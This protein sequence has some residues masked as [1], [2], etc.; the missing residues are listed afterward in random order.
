MPHPFQDK[1]FVFIGKPTRC[2]RQ[3]IRDA[4]IAVGGVT[5]DTLTTFADVPRRYEIDCWRG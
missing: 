1:L 2:S 3:E 5:D 4:L